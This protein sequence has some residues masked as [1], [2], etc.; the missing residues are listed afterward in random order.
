MEQSIWNETDE[1]KDPSEQPRSSRAFE[2]ISNEPTRVKINF[3][4]NPRP[5]ACLWKIATNIDEPL[6][7]CYIS[8]GSMEG[9]AVEGLG[10]I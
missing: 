4:A 2:Q 5:T 10:T 1:N 9:K 7:D 3:R 8:N 6:Q